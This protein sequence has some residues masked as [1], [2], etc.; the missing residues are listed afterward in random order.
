VAN[1]TIYVSDDDLPLFQRAQELSGEN[2]SATITSALRAFINAREAHNNGFHEVTLQVGDMAAPQYKRFL[3]ARIGRA[4]RELGDGN[5]I[6][7]LDVYRTP[8]DRLVLHT[9]HTPD[10]SQWRPPYEWQGRW[11]ASTT[12]G[13]GWYPSASSSPSSWDWSQWEDPSHCALEV[14]DSLDAIVERLPEELLQRIRAAIESPIFEV[15][16]I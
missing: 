5:G 11:A 2:L 16:D 13:Q 12:V 15:L 4:C 10:W 3:N 8:K 7:Q 14:F 6:D 9:R 1:K